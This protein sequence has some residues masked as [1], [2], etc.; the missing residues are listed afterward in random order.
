LRSVIGENIELEFR[1]ESH[2]GSVEADPGQLEQVIIN[3]AIN[4]RDATPNGGKLSIT[5]SNIY[6][7]EAYVA[8]R[9]VVRPG[10]YVQLVVSDTGSGM[11][12]ETQSH[13]FEPFFTPRNWERVRDSPRYRIRH[14]E[15]KWWLRLGV[16]RARPRHRL[17][18]LLAHG[19]DPRG[20]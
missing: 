3:L 19:G 12:E 16:Q 9:V 2:L 17:Q 15:A 6:L 5:T 14:R 10:S 4:A 11:E 8:R 13:I 18:N 7:D 20:K 1:S